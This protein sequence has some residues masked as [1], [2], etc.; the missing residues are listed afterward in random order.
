MEQQSKELKDYQDT[1]TTAEYMDKVGDLT[2]QAEQ[3]AIFLYHEK[4]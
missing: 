3:D 1:F 2:L 4:P